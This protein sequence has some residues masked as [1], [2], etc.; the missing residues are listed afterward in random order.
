MPPKVATF[1]KAVIAYTEGLDPKKADKVKGWI[2]HNG[3]KYS[4]EITDDVTHLIISSK[5]WNNYK[6]QPMGKS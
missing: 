5:A 1:R 4:K 3:A 2:E 6:Q